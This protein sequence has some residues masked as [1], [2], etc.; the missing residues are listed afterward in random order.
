MCKHLHFGRRCASITWA[1]E[2]AKGACMGEQELPK[3][4]QLRT[5]FQAE[6][7]AFRVDMEWKIDV[8]SF[9]FYFAEGHENRYIFELDQDVLQERTVAELIQQIERK[10][11]KRV[12]EA[13][14]GQV[15]RYSDN[16]F[17][18]RAR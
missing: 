10:H 8:H 16:G 14:I 12:L 7:P 1:F 13:H 5:Y 3:E 17:S 2:F 18:F 11:W 9:R 15:V 6:M 4:Q